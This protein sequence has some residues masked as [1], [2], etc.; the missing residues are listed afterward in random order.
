MSR[1]TFFKV[2]KYQKIILYPVLTASCFACLVSILCLVY[3]FLLQDEKPITIREYYDSGVLV[4]QKSFKGD[5]PIS[6][7]TAK[8]YDFDLVQ[9]RVLI[10]WFIATVIAML[11]FVIYWSLYIT[12]KLVGPYERV[13][14]ELD[15]V[16]E[17]KKHSP[18]IAR[19]GDELFQ[20]ILKRINAL[21]VKSSAS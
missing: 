17:G 9:F 10:P 5:K 11:L 7:I 20:E 6:S 14:K 21:I 13:L 8:I 12:H 1:N 4:A 16:I 18:I 15:E 19:K 2:N 3:F